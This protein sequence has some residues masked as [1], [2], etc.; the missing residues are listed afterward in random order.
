[1][2]LVDPAL[3]DA[4]HKRGRIELRVPIGAEGIARLFCLGWL[5]RNECQQ[6]AVLVE[7]LID[8]ANAALN[9]GLRPE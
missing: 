8:V 7:V 3:L 9:A 4:L 6:P 2:R 5:D 1:M